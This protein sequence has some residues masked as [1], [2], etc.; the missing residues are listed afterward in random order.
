M[1]LILW[2][3]LLS[4]HSKLGRLILLWMT[5]W[6][7]RRTIIKRKKR[8]APWWKNPTKIL[9]FQFW[10][11]IQLNMRRKRTT[12][13][14]LYGRLLML[15]LSFLLLP[16]WL[17]FYNLLVDDPICLF[18]TKTRTQIIKNS[19][20]NIFIKFILSNR[21]RIKRNRGFGFRKGLLIFNICIVL[22]H[23]IV[24]L[25]DLFYNSLSSSYTWRATVC[26][27]NSCSIYNNE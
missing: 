10:M 15:L 22:I 23:Q 5:L 16:N 18:L 6:C 26:R 3:V 2:I 1:I 7:I 27:D 21:L 4:I 20:D 17:G 19:L 11:R 8:R 24:L 12:T 14:L 9:R 13:G 25:Q